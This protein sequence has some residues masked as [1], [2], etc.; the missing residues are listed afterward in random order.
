MARY[1][2]KARNK[3]YEITS[4]NKGVAAVE[5]I[6]SLVIIFKSQATSLVNKIWNAITENAG[7]VTG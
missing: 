5:V 6:L 7:K 2:I 3:F 1:I 4:N